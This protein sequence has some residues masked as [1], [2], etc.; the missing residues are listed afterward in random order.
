M[1]SGLAE[2]AAASEKSSRE[3]LAYVLSPQFDR[4][5]LCVELTWKTDGR[6][7]SGLG[8]SRQWGGLD[9]VTTVM[10]DIVFGNAELQR[11]QGSL[12]VLRHAR[13]ASITVTY[14][15][16]PDTRAFDWPQT[17]HP[18]TTAR[19]F[20]GMGN[21]FLLV[22]HD[23]EGVSQ[24]E[25]EVT[26]RWRLAAGQQAACSWGVGRHVGASLSAADLRSSVY[27]AGDIRTR[28]LQQDGIDLEVALADGL[29]FSPDRFAEHMLPIIRAK[30]DFMRDSEFPSFVITAIP[31]G[32]PAAAGN[33][34]LAGSGLYHSFALFAPPESKLD[35]AVEHLFAH[36]LF[37]HWN[38]RLLPAA[39][40]ERQV[41]WFVE[42]FTDYYA[43]RILH[44][45]G[46]WK[47][48]TFCKWLNRHLRDYARNPA[49]NATNAEIEQR[50]WSDRNTY[51]EV[52]YQ[53]GLALALRW[54]HLARKNGV[55]TGID[56]WVRGMVED[57]RRGRLKL[58]NA[59][60]RRRGASTLGA[61]FTE[62]FDRYVVAAAEVEV[63]PPAL[64]PH[65]NG[66]AADIFDYELGFDRARSFERRRVS[67]LKAD[68]AAAAAGLRNGDE[69][70]GWSVPSEE[71]QPV[72]LKVR[73]GERVETIRY[74]PHG[75]KRVVTQF[76]PASPG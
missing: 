25:F 68:S 13:G 61:W 7:A 27:L 37:H 30:R 26:L 6:T 19:F 50:F 52:A 76:A 5:T 42:G 66:K 39:D 54:H 15:V 36:E 74:L 75:R 49:K 17:H 59:E 57:G 35:D 62:E 31:V 64:L 23:E 4:G 28:R 12:W 69:L 10:R 51:G 3:Q 18:I 1:V 21:A 70:A 14:E 67:G 65:F 71:D 29:G 22:P 9:D 56:E 34:R 72:Q 40:P 24:R 8:V 16:R 33:V 43:L 20:H 55:P 73:R 38:G 46:R 2:V 45:S 47:A 58:S 53:R 60:L 41:F 32:E 11:R 44:E 48:E 63:P